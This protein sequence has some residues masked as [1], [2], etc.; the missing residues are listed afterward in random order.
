M[1]RRLLRSR[2]KVIVGHDARAFCPR[3]D[4][5]KRYAVA[6]AMAVAVSALVAPAAVG[7]EDNG[8]GNIAVTYGVTMNTPN[9]AKAPNGDRVRVQ[10]T[11][12]LGGCGT[13][14]TKDKAVDLSGTFV[15]T[16]SGGTVIG[17]GTWVA[18]EL[19]SYESYGCGVVD[20]DGPGGS[21][22]VTIPPFICGGA[23]KTSVLLTAGSQQF[24]GILTIFCIVGENPPN[25]HD[26]LSEEGVTLNIPGVINFNQVDFEGTNNFV[27]LTPSP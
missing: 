17:A 8:T 9:G 3:R 13:F 6:I 11:F 12:G 10:C 19:I 4:V 14:T 2:E 15:H 23:L 26:E 20:F 16:D 21:P 25:S 27:Q 5:M 18:T 7:H 1:A 24:E 22:P